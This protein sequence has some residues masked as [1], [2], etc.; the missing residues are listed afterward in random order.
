MRYS[1]AS[2]TG[3]A[4]HAIEILCVY[5]KPWLRLFDY[6]GLLQRGKVYEVRLRNGMQF[7][8]RGGSS[9][10]QVID[11]VFIH[12]VYDR[13]LDAIEVGH[14]V[15]DIG[16]HVGMFAMA[17]AARGARVVC[18]EPLPSN[19]ELLK[20][21]IAA[22]NVADR[23]RAN[24]LAV[25]GTAGEAELCV[26]DGDTGGSTAFPAIHPAW[27]KRDVRRIPVKCITLRDVLKMSDLAVC[28]CLKIDCEGAEYDILDNADESDLRRIR[29]IIME[30]HPNGQPELLAKRLEDLGFVTEIA[31]KRALMFARMGTP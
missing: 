2:V 10:F 30:F 23:V 26:V 7:S 24:Q 18:F 17:A 3:K 31:P 28:D 21:N 5:R 11:E 16:S 4:R 15:V 14:G 12:G 22:N 8:V 20:R 29:A 1:N 25:A 13:G 19:F 9:D 27:A 6:F